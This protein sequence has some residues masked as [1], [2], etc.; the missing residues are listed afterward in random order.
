MT[1]SFLIRNAPMMDS[2]REFKKHSV[3]HV[4]SEADAFVI[5]SKPWISIDCELSIGS[6]LE[7]DLSGRETK[8]LADGTLHVVASG[9]IYK[10]VGTGVRTKAGHVSLDEAGLM[11]NVVIDFLDRVGGVREFMS[12]LPLLCIDSPHAKSI[13]LVI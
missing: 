12:Y 4:N 11:S 1:S 9:T 10:A 7:F 3:V 5:K 13:H 2:F 8:A 6:E